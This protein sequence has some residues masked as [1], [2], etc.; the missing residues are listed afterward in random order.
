[1][2]ESWNSALSFRMARLR[3]FQPDTQ[4]KVGRKIQQPLSSAAVSSAQMQFLQK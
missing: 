1:M 3:H 4:T 2:D